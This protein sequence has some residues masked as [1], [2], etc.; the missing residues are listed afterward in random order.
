MIGEGE[1]VYST[2]PTSSKY[3]LVSDLELNANN[4][5]KKIGGM[6]FYKLPWFGKPYIAV[7]NDSTWLA[8]QVLSQT[9]DEKKELKSGESW[10]LGKNYSLVANQVDVDGKKVWFSLCKNGREIESGIVNTDGTLA[11]RIFTAT[12]DIGS[13]SDQLYFITYVDSV[14]TSSDSFLCSLQIHLAY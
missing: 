12:A 4:T 9:G 11:D 6:F 7:G 10:I 14:F 2:R 8:N 13:G 1:L 3:E 5:P